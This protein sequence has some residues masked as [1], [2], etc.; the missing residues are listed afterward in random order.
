MILDYYQDTSITALAECS[1]SSY[2][3][4]VTAAATYTVLYKSLHIL[5][6]AIFHQATLAWANVSI[7][8]YSC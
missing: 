8:L 2:L 1:G 5:T 3:H 4:F 6:Y 7:S